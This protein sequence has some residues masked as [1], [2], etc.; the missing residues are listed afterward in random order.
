MKDWQKKK[1]EH[2]QKVEKV[3]K[4]SL[5]QQNTKTKLNPSMKFW[6]FQ[7]MCFDFQFIYA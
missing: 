6:N 4:Q 2:L 3:K 7:F 5:E 1:L